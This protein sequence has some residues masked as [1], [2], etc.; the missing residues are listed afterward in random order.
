MFGRGVAV[1]IPYM[2][3]VS[4]PHGRAFEIQVP[5]LG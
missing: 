3:Q 2:A 5:L 4:L 1:V